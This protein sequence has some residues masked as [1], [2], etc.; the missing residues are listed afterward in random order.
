M[1][2]AATDIETTPKNTS[3]SRE[4]Y[5]PMAT[6]TTD[7]NRKTARKATL[8]NTPESKLLIGAGALL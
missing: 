5:G 7:L 3:S 6:S 8:S 4:K 1:I 2:K